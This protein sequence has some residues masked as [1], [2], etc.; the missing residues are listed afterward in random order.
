MARIRSRD[1][2]PEVAVRRLAHSLGYRFRLYRR[3]LPGA[4]DLVFAGRRK[5]IFIH[6]C[7]WHQHAET[8]CKDS[9]RPNSNQDYWNPKLAKTIAR[10]AANIER[11]SD[12]GWHVLVIW[13]CEIPDTSKLIAR[14]KAFLD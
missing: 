7:F 2:S 6:G 5:V 8:T 3:D 1:T 11:L 12:A 9:R 10:D 13:A 4:P 14:L